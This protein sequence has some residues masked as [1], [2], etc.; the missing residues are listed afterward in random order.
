M[1]DGTDFPFWAAAT[2]YTR[3]YFVA[4]RA[5]AASDENPGTEEKPFRTINHAAQLVQP[6]ERVVVRAGVYREFVQ[7]ARGGRGPEA[8]I[9]YEAAPGEHVVISGS[10][11]ITARWERSMHPHQFSE[12]LWMIP[13]PAPAAADDDPFLRANCR[14]DEF[15][16]MPWAAPYTGL[17]PYTLGRGLLFQDGRRLVQMETYADLIQVPGSFWVDRGAEV[18]HVHAFADRDPNA[19]MMEYTAQHRLFKPPATDLGYVRV[20]GFHFQHA[21]NGLPRTGEGAVGVNGGHHWVF[22]DDWFEQINSVALEIGARTLE[23]ADDAA[24]DADGRRAEASPGANIVRHCEFAECGR[25]GVQGYVV[26]NALVEDNYVH[27]CGWL[28]VERYFES[29]GIKLLRNTGTLVRHN[30]VARITGAPAIW[31][32]WDNRNCRITRNVVSDTSSQANGAIF[33]EASRQPNTI[34]HNLVWHVHGR[35][36][37][38]GDTDRLVI[39]HNLVAYSDREPVGLMTVTDRELDGRRM[40]SHGHIVRDNLFVGATAPVIRER[41]N[42]CDDNLYLATLPAPKLAAWRDGGWDPHG[43]LL[44]GR[45]DFDPVK[46]DLAVEAAHPLPAVPIVPPF[47]EDFFGAPRTGDTTSAGP[48]ADGHRGRWK[49]DP[50]DFG[51]RVE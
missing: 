25:N 42:V 18:L 48:I 29:A 32:D 19:C 27:D 21:G 11:V 7:P 5:P 14:D 22:E 28:D 41:D 16:I 34:D 2:R 4:Q 10:R 36:I 35:G 12:K 8:M 20:K 23:S 37:F 44:D 50:R 24:D 26:R 39:A 15:K 38:A 40:S 43:A 6:G 17:A 46:G 33:I 1:P 45:C 47:R 51:V 30:R 9:S 31:L 3:T 13:L 49:I